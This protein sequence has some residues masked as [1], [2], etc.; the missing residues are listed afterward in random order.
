MLANRTASLWL[1]LLWLG[2]SLSLPTPGKAQSREARARA[3]FEAGRVYVEAKDYEPAL[4]EFKAAYALSPRPVLL[5]NIGLAAEN[6]GKPA[7]A[8]EAYDAFVASGE[9]G[10]NEA[11]LRQRVTEL[12][13]EA[14]AQA[15]KA[16]ADA[17]VAAAAAAPAV[18]GPG[19]TEAVPDSTSEPSAVDSEPVVEAEPV[20][21]GPPAWLPWVVVGGGGALAVTGAVLLGVGLGDVSAVEDAHSGTRWGEVSD[22]NDR[23]PT[24][25]GLGI[26]LLGVGAATAVSGLMWWSLSS[27]EASDGSEVAVG[28]LPTG[29]RVTGNF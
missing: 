12:R 15:R 6:A 16:E 2:A 25:T 18:D 7:E 14:A 17:A 20:E 13:A 23:A 29:L 26:A 22:Q 5:F 11:A 3:H 19:Q 27:G 24:L 1:S 10:E 9:S 21:G 28:V 4:A 8:A